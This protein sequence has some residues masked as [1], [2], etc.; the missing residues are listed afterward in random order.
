MALNSNGI[1]VLWNGKTVAT[2]QAKGLSNG[3]NDW[4]HYSFT[5][6]GG[7]DALSRLEFRAVGTSDS[8]GGSLDKVSLTS[9]VPE[10][11]TYAMLMVGAGLIGFAAR[12]KK[13]QKF[14]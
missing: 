2:E 8:Y 5:V 10:P 12:R 6:F 1:E 7:N 11:D 9:A 3:K 4:Q 14:N 13:N